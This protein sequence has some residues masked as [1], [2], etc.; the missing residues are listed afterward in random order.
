MYCD[1]A[2]QREAK[3]GISQTMLNILGVLAAA[4]CE[5]VRISGKTVN[6]MADRV[7]PLIELKDGQARI[8][9]RGLKEWQKSEFV[10][11]R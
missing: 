11:T 2:C 3:A 7:V 8:T 6:L 9:E 1:I 5:W 4:G 10:T